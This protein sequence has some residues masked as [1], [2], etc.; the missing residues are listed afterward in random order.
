MLLLLYRRYKF[1][2]FVEIAIALENNEEEKA[3]AQ[4]ALVF[5]DFDG[6]GMDETEREILL[7][8]APQSYDRIHKIISARTMAW[9][10]VYFDMKYDAIPLNHRDGFSKNCHTHRCRC[11]QLVQG[12]WKTTPSPHREPDLVR[13][14]A[15]AESISSQDPKSDSRG[16]KNRHEH[17]GRPLLPIV[18]H[19]TRRDVLGRGGTTS[20]DD[21]P[22]A[23]VR[24][25][26]NMGSP[27]ERTAMWLMTWENLG[28]GDSKTLR[29]LS[30]EAWRM[31]SSENNVEICPYQ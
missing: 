11:L 21:A 23:D 28:I 19:P 29:V 9:Q 24:G 25:D 30:G 31:R 17:R 3:K 15:L 20:Q 8:F 22:H 16:D 18:L 1:S 12:D 14:R 27:P 6:D 26:V 2:E 13:N 10:Q 4:A 7:H 5:K